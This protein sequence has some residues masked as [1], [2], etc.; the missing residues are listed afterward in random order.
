[1]GG[2]GVLPTH[3]RPQGDEGASPHAQKGS[4]SNDLFTSNLWVVKGDANY[5]RLLDDRA[6]D[7]TTPLADLLGYLPVPALM[8]RML[9]SEMVAG[10]P[11]HLPSRLDGLDPAWRVNGHWGLLDFWQPA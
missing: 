1:M 4:Q 11:A 7:P 3:G 8:I 6:Y 5:R 10:L 9:K 2:E